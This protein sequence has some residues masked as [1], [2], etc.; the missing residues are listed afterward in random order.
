MKDEYKILDPKIEKRLKK[1]YLKTEWKKKFLIDRYS[2]IYDWSKQLPPYKTL[3]DLY[4]FLE[5]NNNVCNRDDVESMCFTFAYDTVLRNEIMSLLA[6]VL[7]G[8]DNYGP[9]SEWYWY[10]K[11]NNL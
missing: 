9:I 8:D 6:E 2:N 10:G 3:Y 1:S 7:T 4:R 5:K 11:R